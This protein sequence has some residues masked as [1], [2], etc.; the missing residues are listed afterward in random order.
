MKHSKHIHAAIFNGGDNYDINTACNFLTAVK[1]CFSHSII[2]YAYSTYDK[3]TLIDLTCGQKSRERTP[4]ILSPIT[5]ISPLYLRTPI[6][7]AGEGSGGGGPLS[8]TVSSPQSHPDPD[9]GISNLTETKQLLDILSPFYNSI[10]PAS[11][12]LELMTYLTTTAEKLTPDSKMLLFLCSQGIHHTSGSLALGRS[13]T[14]QEIM[15]SIETLPLKC[16]VVIINLATGSDDRRL[17][18][19]IFSSLRSLPG[20]ID[21]LMQFEIPNPSPPS[22]SGPS[23]SSAFSFTPIT[24]PV[25]VGDSSSGGGAIGPGAAA[26]CGKGVETHLPFGKGLY[27]VA[28]VDVIQPTGPRTA[29]HEVT[30]IRDVGSIPAARG[31]F[32]AYETLKL[33]PWSYGLKEWELVEDVWKFV[34]E[35]VDVHIVVP[36]TSTSMQKIKRR[37]GIRGGRVVLGMGRNK[38]RERFDVPVWYLEKKTLD[39]PDSGIATMA[40]EGMM[41]RVVKQNKKDA[42]IDEAVNSTFLFQKR[43]E[44][45]LRF[46]ERTD[47][48]VEAFL[49]GCYKEGIFHFLD[50]SHVE[51][52][53]DVLRR[54]ME[55]FGNRTELFWRIVTPPANC[56]KMEYLARAWEIAKLAES[57]SR[58]YGWFRMDRFL[59]YMDR[60]L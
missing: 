37:V 13:I 23:S 52:E 8:P 30:R 12:K 20:S 28:R 2:P 15:E 3:E 7:P 10:P 39:M 53:A 24:S 46:I 22:A 27:N 54:L 4:S 14:T 31:L 55:E 36:K 18:A 45:S 38:E 57:H 43:V 59:A 9:A 35:T 25:V 44:E 6:T 34:E 16:T 58:R 50:P 49:Q 32:A 41:R 42:P 5:P 19:G 21:D 33:A 26:V 47:M 48:R 11:I 56:V 29:E 40:L 51:M 17:H 1:L 60:N